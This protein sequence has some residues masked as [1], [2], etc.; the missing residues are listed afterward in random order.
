MTI[1]PSSL[2]PLAA[3]AL[4]VGCA[5]FRIAYAAGYRAACREAARMVRCPSRP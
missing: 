1:P 3:V 5:L 2:A 4:V